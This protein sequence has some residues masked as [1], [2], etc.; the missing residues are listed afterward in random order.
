MS[1]QELKQKN[2]VLSEEN[3]RLRFIL[4]EVRKEAESYK[5]MLMKYYAEEAKDLII[6]DDHEL[7][8]KLMTKLSD[9]PLPTRAKTILKSLNCENLGDILKLQ[10]NDFLKIRNCGKK[11][12][13]EINNVVELYDLEWGMDVD[14]I[15]CT[16]MLHYFDKK[17]KGLE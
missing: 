3:Y 14:K 13:E 9:L 11:T 4:N 1:I 8:M 2:K 16:D 12:L 6:D 5:A 15:I 7:A 10:K 17:E